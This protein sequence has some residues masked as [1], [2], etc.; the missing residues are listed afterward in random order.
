[1][2][3]LVGTLA[4][5]HRADP[6]THRLLYDQAPR[7]PEAARRLR[8]FQAAMAAEVEHH[9][10]R[11]DAGGPDRALT[12]LL[13]VQALEAQVHGAV[14]DPPPGRTTAESVEAAVRLCLG[15]LR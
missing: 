14:L 12:A 15:A 10:A 7:P 8:E 9:L 2:R 13:L 5:V 4:D 1:M 3:T 6:A 11:L